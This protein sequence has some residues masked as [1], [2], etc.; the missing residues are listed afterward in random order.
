MQEKKVAR[1][2]RFEAAGHF[3]NFEIAGML[4]TA[5]RER[6]QMFFREETDHL[7]DPIAVCE[8]LTEIFD[9]AFLAAMN[10]DRF[11]N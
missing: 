3:S 7:G 10:A 6:L 5:Q 2:K 9:T 1:G 8:L 4:N 11:T